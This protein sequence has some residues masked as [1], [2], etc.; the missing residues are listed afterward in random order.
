MTVEQAAT[1]LGV[2]HTVIRRLIREGTLPASQVVES[3]PWIIA[4][5]SLTLDRQFKRPL[6]PSAAAANCPSETPNKP[7]SPSNNAF[8]RSYGSMSTPS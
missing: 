7:N 6:P 1:E 5:E 8:S 2:S 3:T 4:R